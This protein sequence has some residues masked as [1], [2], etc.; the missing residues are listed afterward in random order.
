[1]NKLFIAGSLLL[2]TS[3]C[4]KPGVDTTQFYVLSPHSAPTAHA[5]EAPKHIVFASLELPECLSN[6]KIMSRFSPTHVYYEHEHRWAASLRSLCREA[7]EAHLAHQGHLCVPSTDA[8][9]PKLHVLIKQFEAGPEDTVVL[10][11]QWVVST[12]NQKRRY[13]A[14]LSEPYN[15]KSH[16]Y[17]A[18]TQAMASTLSALSMRIAQS[19]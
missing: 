6:S 12:P 2:L 11:A 15:L 3:G 16:N 7:I 9:V 4:F 17:P 8:A 18:L 14:T 19:L 13:Q 1:M 5:Q 10:V